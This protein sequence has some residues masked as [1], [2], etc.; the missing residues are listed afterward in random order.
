M[1][2]FPKNPLQPKKNMFN[3]IFFFHSSIAYKEESNL[4]EFFLKID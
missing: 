1:I 4:E 3:Q 2:N